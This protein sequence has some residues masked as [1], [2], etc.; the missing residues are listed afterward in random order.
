MSQQKMKELKKWDVKAS[1]QNGL[2]S[3]SSKLNRILPLPNLVTSKESKEQ[4]D[5]LSYAVKQT[6]NDSWKTGTVDN[7]CGSIRDTVLSGGKTLD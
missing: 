4:G 3:A 1:S 7:I 5:S 2:I 6:L